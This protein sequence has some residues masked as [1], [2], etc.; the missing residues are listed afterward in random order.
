MWRCGAEETT[1]HLLWDY[2]SSQLSWENLNSILEDRNLRLDKIVS[3]EKVFD[4]G[5]TACATL[6]K[7]KIIN[8]FIQIERPK[9]LTKSKFIHWLTN[10]KIQRN[11]LQLKTKNFNTLKWGWNLSFKIKV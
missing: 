5:G 4:F 8:E 10:L 11:I 3:Y 2:P 7:L 1:K 9:H 6:T